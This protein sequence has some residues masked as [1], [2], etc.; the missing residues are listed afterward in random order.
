MKRKDLGELQRHRVVS[1]A[2][3]LCA[4]VWRREGRVRSFEVSSVCNCCFSVWILVGCKAKLSQRHLHS[5][6]HSVDGARVLGNVS[7]CG[8]Y[9]QKT[10]IKGFLFSVLPSSREVLREHRCSQFFCSFWFCSASAT[11]GP[12]SSSRPHP[13]VVEG[14]EVL[15]KRKDDTAARR[16]FC[17]LDAAA[18][19]TWWPLFFC[20]A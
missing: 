17:R 18:M 6:R 10:N 20:R 5:H 8:N 2:R 7:R 15:E 13:E 4:L 11:L 12:V 14:S 1:H 19:L 3:A 16:G 9:K